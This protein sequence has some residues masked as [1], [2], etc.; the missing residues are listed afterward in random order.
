MIIL[1][2]T[3]SLLINVMIMKIVVQIKL[4]DPKTHTLR[5]T[6]VHNIS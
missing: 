4:D 6:A 2:I 5:N 1:T 3:C